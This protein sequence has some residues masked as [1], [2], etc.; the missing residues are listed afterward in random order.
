M[1]SFRTSWKHIRRAPYQA[2]AA[3]TIIFLTFFIFTT[4]ALRS[5]N[6]EQIL[7]HFEAKPQAIAFF[8]DSATRDQ[9][10]ALMDKLER[11]EKVTEL[12]Y[13]SKEEALA[14][15]REQNK[16]DPLLLDL[17]TADILPASLEVSAIKSS[18]LPELVEMMKAEESVED[19]L[20]QEDV[21]V[22]LTNW[23]QTVRREG[24]QS[25][26]YL[27]IAAILIIFVIISMKIAIKKEEIEILRLLGASTGYIRIPFLLEGIFYGVFGS[28][29]AWGVVYVLLLYRVPFLLHSVTFLPTFLMETSLSL[30]PLYLM[31]YLLGGEVLL[32]AL[33][34]ILASYLAV[35][36]YL[37]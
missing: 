25:I 13:I 28:S 14:I 26:I 1:S 35:R 30:P 15:Y 11:T 17:V 20:F 22:Q 7:Q 21:T 23:A 24:L 12:K 29:L 10:Q 37:R 36:R 18:F 16:D 34:G 6:S 32:G 2:I 27:V 4:S 31:V 5:Y 33:I 19:V 9:I 3:L 8:A